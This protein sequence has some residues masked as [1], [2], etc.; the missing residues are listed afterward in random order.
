ML[1]LKFKEKA[2]MSMS[3]TMRMIQV[4]LFQTGSK[5][6]QVVRSD[7]RPGARACDPQ[8]RPDLETLPF[9]LK[10]SAWHR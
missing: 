10:V 9:I 4:V 6:I 2:R 1:I 8:Q 7:A 5:N 3:M